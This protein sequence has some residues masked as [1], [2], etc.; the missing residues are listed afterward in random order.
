MQFRLDLLSK[1][2]LRDFF[3]LVGQAD[4][5]VEVPPGDGQRIDV[6]H[7]PDPALLLALLE[8]GPGL[9][10]TMA[11]EEGAV[12]IFSDALSEP[13][14]HGVVRKRYCWHHILELRAKQLL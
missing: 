13:D 1:N 14:F 4:T 6:W 8:L 10:R 3:V 2:I 12:E 5:E 11:E 9:L 7:I